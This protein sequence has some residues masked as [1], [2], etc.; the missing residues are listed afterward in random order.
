MRAKL[1][2]AAMLAMS[3]V[4]CNLLLDTPAVK[5]PIKVSSPQPSNQ[6]TKVSLTEEEADYVDAGNELTFRLLPVLSRSLVGEKSFIFSPLSIQYAL[7]MTANGAS[8]ETMEQIVSTLGFG[9]DID[10]LNTLCNKLLNQLPA[11]DLG[12]TLKLADAILV[13]DEYP[14]LPSF[15]DKV[16][17]TYYAAVENMSFEDPSYVAARINDWAS[18]NTNGLIDKMLD[19]SDISPAAIAFLMNA[20]YFKAPWVPKGSDPLFMKES[21]TN[22]A[23]Y[24][25]G[26]DV[27]EVPTMFTSR[28]LK[29]ADLGDFR[30]LEI[31]YASG[32]FAM[33]I[34]L[35]EGEV[36]GDQPDEVPAKYG[37][38]SLLKDFPTLDWKGILSKMD[39][40]D[41]ILA[42]PKFETSSYYRLNDAL[43]GLGMTRAFTSAAEFDRMFE[44]PSVQACIDMVIQKAR[45]SVTEW[46]TEAA[47]V[48]VVGMK[49]TSVGPGEEP[50]VKFTCDHPFAYLIAEK[51]SGA[52]LFAGAYLGN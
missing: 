37:I 21:T 51:T 49:N 14:L 18:R 17:S 40:R 4:S 50:P 45:I 20:L 15:K 35:P 42:L 27:I 3:M 48:T 26:C 10:K 9:P 8:G 19:A 12:V 11:V 47:A 31:P 29:Y 24:P 33:Y 36:V 46:G 1:F 22:K 5:D 52:I 2:A 44:D 41:V 6:I 25:G 28:W 23:F 30:I 13:N 43:K 16:E 34:L 38:A 32:K 39:Y 7:G